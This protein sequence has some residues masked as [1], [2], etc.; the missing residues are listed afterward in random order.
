VLA[1]YLASPLGFSPEW[2]S[3]RDK[4]KRRFHELGCTVLDPWEHSFRPTIGEAGAIRD[5]QARVENFSQIAREIGQANEKMMRSCDA[6]LSVLDGAELDSGT[7]SEIGFGARIGKRC[8]ACPPISE[9]AETSTGFPSTRRSRLSKPCVTPRGCRS[10]GLETSFR[11][12]KTGPGG[13]SDLRSQEES[14]SRACPGGDA[15]AHPQKG[16]GKD[17]QTF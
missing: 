11:S 2:K 7:V 16:T 15:C 17:A 5:W 1:V 8:A 6:V 10:Q 3:Y 13:A 4:I 14:H 12:M 9:T